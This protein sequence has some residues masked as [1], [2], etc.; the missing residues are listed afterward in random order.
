M[1]PAE[2]A[3]LLARGALL[4]C[5]GSA[6]ATVQQLDQIPDYA[7]R[8]YSVGPA[9]SGSDGLRVRS[10]RTLEL[11]GRPFLARGVTYS[12]APIGF[13]VSSASSSM[14]FF[15]S[16]N[17]PIWRRDL[18]VM[19]DMGINTIRVYSLEQ[20]AQHTEFLDLAHALNITV[21]AGFPLHRDSAHLRIA[22]DLQ[23]STHRTLRRIHWRPHCAPVAFWVVLPPNA[24]LQ[25]RCLLQRWCL[26]PALIACPPVQATKDRLRATINANRHAAI[27]MW[28]VGNEV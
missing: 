7:W 26:S 22:S 27:G 4:V 2:A 10:N 16:E 25:C 9:P 24:P 18:P 15:S 14:D 13:D 23:A 20:S 21:L 12:P 28:L 1:L 8:N 19:R 5:L 11:H 17:E 6:A 3:A